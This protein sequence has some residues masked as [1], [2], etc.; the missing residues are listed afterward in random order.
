M[1]RFVGLVSLIAVL[2]AAVVYV[3]AAAGSSTNFT[4]KYSG[5]VHEVVNGSNVTGTPNGKGT[6]SLIGK[7]SMT[8]TVKGNQ[9]SSTGCTPLT[10]TGTLKGSKGT[11][12]LKLTNSPSPSTA[13]GAQDDHNSIDFYGTAKVTGGTGALKKAA[14]SLHYSGHYD[15]GTGA[16]NVKLTGT[17][18]H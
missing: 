12:K 13:C 14:G 1:K 8:G 17:L 16:F 10:G 5:K 7:G 11:L 15:R 18:K 6:A 4:A 3:G 2:A 9:S